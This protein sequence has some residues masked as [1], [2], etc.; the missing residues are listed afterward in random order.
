MRT[1][2][3]LGRFLGIPI[4]I[5]YTWFLIFL[6][7][8][9]SLALFE[10]PQRVPGASPLAYWLAGVGGSLLFFL[11][12]LAHEVAH[13]LAARS[14]GVPVHDV[15]LFIFGGAAGLEREM[16]RPEDELLVAGIGPITSLVLAGL[17]ALPYLLLRTLGLAPLI[18]EALGYLAILNLGLALFNLLPGLPLDGGRILRAVVWQVTHNYRW[19]THVAATAGRTIAMVMI[20]AGVLMALAPGGSFLNGLW[21]AFIGWFLD[22]AAAQSYRHVLLQE[23]LRGV[24]VSD[25]MTPECNRIPR[26][27][28]VADLVDRY[29]LPQGQRCFLVTNGEVLEGLVTLHGVRGLER[30]RWP[31]TPVGEIMVPYERLVVAHP[32]EDAWEVLQRMDARNVNQM[33]VEEAGRLLGLIA[34][35]NLLRYVRIRAELGG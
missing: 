2:F 9:L 17:L 29:I 13:S 25:L 26:G 7:V 18:R 24:T 16:D 4:R 30:E 34:R 23:S 35:E 11:S 27:L 3:R 33:P 20:G 15:T 8:V 32:E 12:V 14:R 6:L 22:N 28:S 10:F 19:A 5:H 21:L 1:S 31:C